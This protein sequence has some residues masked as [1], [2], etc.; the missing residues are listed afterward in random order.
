M[1]MLLVFDWNGGFGTVSGP[2]VRRVFRAH[3]GCTRL[4]QTVAFVVVIRVRCGFRVKLCCD[5]CV[6]GDGYS[7]VR[8]FRCRSGPCCN[9]SLLCLTGAVFG[10]LR[11]SDHDRSGLAWYLSDFLVG[12]IRRS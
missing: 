10:V 2:P 4:C 9:C 1:C 7:T 5:K 8:V 11:G 12:V 6:I 3:A